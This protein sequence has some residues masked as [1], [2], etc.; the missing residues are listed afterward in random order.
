MAHEL[1]KSE[2]QK[3]GLKYKYIAEILGITGVALNKK[4]NGVSR[5]Y[6]SEAITICNL[7]G[8]PVEDISKFFTQKVE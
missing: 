4:M 6:V 8:L 7:L 5:F 3:K 1:L 2:I